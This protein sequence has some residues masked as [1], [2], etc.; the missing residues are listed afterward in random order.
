MFGKGVHLYEAREFILRN[1]SHQEYTIEHD[2]KE[3]FMINIPVKQRKIQIK[4]AE[5]KKGSIM[6]D[7][8]DPFA[9]IRIP[10]KTFKKKEEM[11]SF[12]L[13]CIRRIIVEKSI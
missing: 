7:I 8:I 6:V 11:E 2:S 12:L 9:M 3:C 1:I 5:Y 4:A 10:R 13:D